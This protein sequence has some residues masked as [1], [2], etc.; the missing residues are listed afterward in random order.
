MVTGMVTGM[1]VKMGM[2]IWVETGIMMMTG[3]VMGMAVEMGMGI[4][5]GD[6]EEP[7]VGHSFTL[8]LPGHD[9]VS[10]VPHLDLAAGMISTVEMNLKL[11][12]S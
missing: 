7:K 3:M 1:A 2:G 5:G 6:G 12:V 11:K 10:R 9:L 8:G 4:W